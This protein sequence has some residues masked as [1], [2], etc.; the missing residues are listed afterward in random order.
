MIREVLL[1]NLTQFEEWKYRAGESWKAH[2]S[3]V[4]EQML[5]LDP[6][7]MVFA[8]TKDEWT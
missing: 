3:P 6:E 2:D 4:V 1:R 5:N 7:T 8:R